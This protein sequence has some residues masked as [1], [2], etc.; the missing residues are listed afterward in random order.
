MKCKI[1]IFFVLSSLSLFA[2]GYNLWV[3]QL[4][5]LREFNVDEVVK[6]NDLNTFG[7]VYHKTFANGTTRIYLRDLNGKGFISK[8]KANNVVKAIKKNKKIKKKY[9]NI[10]IEEIENNDIFI[11][12]K[13]EVKERELVVSF[14]LNEPN[15]Q[16][17]QPNPNPTPNVT[18]S[19][20]IEPTYFVRLGFFKDKYEYSI[21]RKFKL[22][23][24]IELKAQTSIPQKGTSFICGNFKE[25]EKAK[26]LL[27]NAQKYSKEKLYILA[28]Q[29]DAKTKKMV[30]KK[31]FSASEKV[32]SK[33]IKNGKANSKSTKKMN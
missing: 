16:L 28:Y 17:P 24:D 21:R 31:V 12:P 13:V 30:Y 15:Q 10:F 6:Y 5:S 25:L 2:Q 8:E 19:S 33:S 22:E 14:K 20:I 23:Q 4:A 7:E 3:L 26:G 18:N 27:I 11:A 29:Q 32:T 1:L 9:K